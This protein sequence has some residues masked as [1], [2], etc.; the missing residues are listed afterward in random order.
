[1]LPRLLALYRERG[2]NF[3]TLEQAE[4]APFYKNDLDLGLPS[5]PDSLEAAMAARGLPLP[6]A[7][8]PGL[9]LDKLCR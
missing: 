1:M 4:S 8:R 3:V 7:P 6:P 2:F 9:D 5:S